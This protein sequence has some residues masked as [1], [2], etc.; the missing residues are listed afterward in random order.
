MPTRRDTQGVMSCEL[1]S[2][3]IPLIT[4]DL[5]VCHEMFKDMDNV[6]LISNNLDIVNLPVAY[7]R[8]LNKASVSKSSKF[9]YVNTVL[10]EEN[11]LRKRV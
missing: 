5:P 1:V 7:D 9:D 2:Y 8:L 6:E 4:S 3:G 11:I 10:K